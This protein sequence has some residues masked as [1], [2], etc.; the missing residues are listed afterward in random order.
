LLADLVALSNISTAIQL[1]I[2]SNESLTS[3]KGL[4]NLHDVWSNLGISNNK[5]LENLKGLELL[6]RVGGHVQIS[7]KPRLLNFEGLSALKNI[8]E[9]FFISDNLRLESLSGLERLEEISGLCVIYENNSLKSLDGLNSL[10]T[11]SIGPLGERYDRSE[12]V[13]YLG[14]LI[15]QKNQEL[16][17]L[18]GLGNLSFV[19]S[20][21]RILDNPLLEDYGLESLEEVQNNLVLHDNPSITDMNGLNRLARVG[22]ELQIVDNSSLVDITGLKNI[23]SIGDTISFQRNPGLSNQ[24][25]LDFVENVVSIDPDK[26]LID[27]PTIVGDSSSRFRESGVGTVRILGKG[28]FH[29]KGVLDFRVGQVDISELRGLR[30]VGSLKLTETDQVNLD[31]LEDLERIEDTLFIASNFQLEN[32]ESL[33][34]LREIGGDLIIGGNPTDENSYFTGNSPIFDL[35]GLRNLTKIGGDLVT[36][37]TQLARK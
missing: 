31:G 12:Y 2:V 3:F 10:E 34:G 26:V 15:I 7:N 37:V 16:K 20:D 28:N 18:R 29:L 5:N 25:I 24:S 21:I 23:T 6:N 22:A 36:H 19:E 32:I 8:A 35:E 9:G 13:P 4:D 17:T 14:N 11:I 27:M 33:C 1:N 30:S